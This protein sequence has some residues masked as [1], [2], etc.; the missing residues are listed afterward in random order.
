MCISFNYS[1]NIRIL[2]DIKKSRGNY[3]VKIAKKFAVATV[4]HYGVLSSLALQ[5]PRSTSGPQWPTSLPLAREGGR[6][7]GP[8]PFRAPGARGKKRPQQ[9]CETKARFPLL[10]NEKCT[11]AKVINN[12]QNKCPK[13]FLCQILF[14]Y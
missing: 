12:W 3:F 4:V 2:F 9:I 5:G 14:V 11:H 8:D 6:G 13:V 1:T 10:H 7:Q